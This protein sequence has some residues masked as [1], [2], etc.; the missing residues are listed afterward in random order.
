[1]SVVLTTPHQK[2]KPMPEVKCARRDRNDWHRT[3]VRGAIAIVRFN[4][5][6]SVD[7]EIPIAP[8]KYYSVFRLTP[9]QWRDI[10]INF[11]KVS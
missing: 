5:D 10:Q 3:T 6:V 11:K 8:R 9:A 4:E 2:Q 1:M 7:V